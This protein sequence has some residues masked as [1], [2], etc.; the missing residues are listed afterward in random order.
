M[1]LLW[2]VA[3]LCAAVTPSLAQE[4]IDVYAS[5]GA[6]FV[7]PLGS[8]SALGGVPTP[9][10]PTFTSSAVSMQPWFTLGADAEFLPKMPALRFGG[11]V[12]IQWYLLDY[13]A[14]EQVPIATEDGGK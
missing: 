12:G 4:K 2:L 8:F 1:C 5:F 6:A 13:G 9:S 10:D 7:A 14:S 11:R 3:L